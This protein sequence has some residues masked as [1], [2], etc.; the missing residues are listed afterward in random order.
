M[1]SFGLSK[2]SRTGRPPLKNTTGRGINDSGI[3]GRTLPET[4]SK[5]E[6]AEMSALEL[7]EFLELESQTKVL[8][9]P[10]WRGMIPPQVE[11][12]LP[13]GLMQVS[14]S[15]QILGLASQT[16]TPKPDLPEK[17]SMTIARRLLLGAGLE[18]STSS[19]QLHGNE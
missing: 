4:D 16:I 9:Q 2:G 19:K 15:S 6:V 8:S 13:P 14:K 10:N 1:S 3:K 18:R 17:R 12:T 11:M 7:K 5:T